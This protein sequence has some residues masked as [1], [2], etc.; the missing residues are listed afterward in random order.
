M[1]KFLNILGSALCIMFFG[2]NEDSARNQ[3]HKHSI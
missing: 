2:Y 1:I 3:T